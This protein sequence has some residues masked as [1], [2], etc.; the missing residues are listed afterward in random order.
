MLAIRSEQ[1]QAFVPVLRQ[2]ANEQLAA[3]A[4]RRFP[5]L[6]AESDDEKLM[7]LAEEVRAAAEAYGFEQDDHVATFLDL[8]VMYGSGFPQSPWAAPILLNAYL[9][10]D[11]KIGRLRQ[12]VEQSGIAL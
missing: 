4:R 8:W 1:I 12:R 6:F 10:P 5:D 2:R 7:T 9:W 11:E 3:Y